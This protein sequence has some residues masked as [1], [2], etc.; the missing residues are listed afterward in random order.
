MAAL[1]ETRAACVGGR[2]PLNAAVCAILCVIT[3]TEYHITQK[4]L[5]ADLGI[6]LRAYPYRTT[7]RTTP[8]GGCC[9]CRCVLLWP[10]LRHH[11][12]YHTCC[13][14]AVAVLAASSYIPYVL[15]HHHTYHTCHTYP[16]GYEE[17]AAHF[18]SMMGEG[19]HF[20]EESMVEMQRRAA[21]QASD[22]PC[23]VRREGGSSLVIGGHPL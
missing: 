13:C 21:E 7:C 19:G 23:N 20:S 14:V 2:D 9:C 15:R 1:R 12:T 17:T 18:D 4:R 8:H 3:T 11:H 16:G 6:P 22:L 5:L 10:C